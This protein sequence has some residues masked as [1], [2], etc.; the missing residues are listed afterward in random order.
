MDSPVRQPVSIAN[1][2]PPDNVRKNLHSSQPNVHLRQAQQSLGSFV[3]V[4]YSKTRG[5][6]VGMDI[7]YWRGRVQFFRENRGSRWLKLKPTS[8]R[9]L[10]AAMERSLHG[11]Q[12]S[13]SS[14]A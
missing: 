3:I 1:S 12:R 10:M 7:A 4:E 5:W 14:A 9:H 11:S 8:I 2:Y 13:S 6:P